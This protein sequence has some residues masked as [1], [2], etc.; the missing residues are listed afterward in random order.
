MT[1]DA[2]SP[3]QGRTVALGVSG[4]I[5]AYKAA[6]L[7]SKLVQAGATV[8]PILTRGALRFVQP[9]VFSGLTRQPVATD[10]FDEPWGASVIAHLHYA[11][12]VDL[13]VIA[14]ASADLLARLAVGLCDDMLTSALAANLHKPVL[15]APAMNSDMWAHPAT[16]ANRKTLES[17]GYRFIEP[18][19][20]RLAE[21]IVG[22][23]R[24]AEPPDILRAVLDTLHSRSDLSGLSVLVTAG[25]TRE[26]I[27]PVRFI[28]NRS[29]GKMGYAL[30]DAAARR[31]AR[32]TLVSGPVSL[33]V[34]FGVA[35]VV[36]AD[37]AAQMEEAVLSRA[38]AQDV[39]VQAAAI[40]DFRPARIADH[41]IKK[42]EGLPAIALEPN[43][44]FSVTLGQRK[45]PGQTLVGFAAETNDLGS[46]ARAKL[47]AKNLDLIVA[48]D[49]TQ[50]GA[51]F[52]VDTNIVSLLTPDGGA[53]ELPQMPKRAVADAL[54]DRVLRL[55]A[56]S[57][58]S[59]A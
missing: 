18:G 49:V 39:I 1:A 34:P 41:K 2:A 10:A 43:R 54:W 53:E 46:N 17:R 4:S 33:P 14:P 30:A 55:R 5:S 35:E 20:G 23:G 27:D 57:D 51:G 38:D 52:D 19:V 36:R 58:A 22:A 59:Q 13:F 25:P 21:G 11:G 37:T 48:N 50:A 3:L 9:A 47:A 26:P 40:A 24:L 28:S 45:R 56:Q 32:V 12:A 8:L 44:D 16:Q 15:I 29:S 31:G 7:C 42:S 6:D